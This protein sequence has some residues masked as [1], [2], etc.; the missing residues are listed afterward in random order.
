MT[1][2]AHRSCPIEYGY[3]TQS[4]SHAADALRDSEADLLTG[5]R[6]A[7]SGAAPQGCPPVVVA[8]TAV[9]IVRLMVRVLYAF[10]ISCAVPRILRVVTLRCLILLIEH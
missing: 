2:G 6:K 7:L 5:C 1:L 9:T 10:N 8:K 3:R 4:L